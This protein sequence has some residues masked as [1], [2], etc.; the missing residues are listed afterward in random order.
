MN[1]SQERLL[2]VGEAQNRIL[3]GVLPLDLELI[4][5]KNA[6]GR[7]LAEKLFVPFDLPAFSN[8]SMDGFAVRSS[9]VSGASQT[10]PVSL[11]VIIDIPAGSGVTRKIEP[12]QAA[13]IMTGAMIPPGADAVI[14]IE[15]TDVYLHKIQKDM[16]NSVLIYRPLKSGEFIRQAGQ[17]VKQGEMLLEKGCL[18]GPAQ[19]GLCAMFG[20]QTVP[21]FRKP[22]VA[23]L[24]S[25]NE[26]MNSGDHFVPGKIYDANSLMLASL[27]ERCGGESYPLGIVPDHQQ[28]IKDRL[29]TTWDLGID[30]IISSAGVSVGAFDYMRQVIEEFGR[31]DFWKVN[32][33]PGKPVI[34]GDYR[35]VRY[36]G[37]PG[38]PVSAFVGFLVFIEPLL[39]K[40][41]GSIQL[42]RREINVSL[43]DDI[44][45]DGRQ[46]YIRAMVTNDQGRLVGKLTGQQGSG[47]IF[48]LGHANTLLIIPSGVKSVRSGEEVKAWPLVDDIW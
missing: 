40:M 13:R 12:G 38:N 37:L 41:T 31:I 4:D 21:V 8:S 35:G 19:L 24:A 18:L 46:S 28:L 20:T 2:E 7:I 16:P 23:I 32:M 43:L 48:S 15:D 11:K 29:D 30:V 26:L 34:S 27:V 22:K 3:D 39:K 1:K 5:I 47:D 45:S 14:P 36:L 44:Q 10:H 33:R 42:F 9:D 6:S 25:G 17:D